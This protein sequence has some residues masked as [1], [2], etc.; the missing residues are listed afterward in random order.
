VSPLEGNAED[1]S[2]KRIGTERPFFGLAIKQT[3]AGPAR[4]LAPFVT[5][6][7]GVCLLL[8]GDGC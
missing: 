4:M 8:S 6:M 7:N 3:K 1:V 2:G 5:Q